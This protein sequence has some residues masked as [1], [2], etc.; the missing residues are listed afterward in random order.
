MNGYELQFYIVVIGVGL[1]LFLSL[2]REILM[3]RAQQT[4]DEKDYTSSKNYEDLGEKID[5]LCLKME[6]FKS[7]MRNSDDELLM[8]LFRCLNE[9]HEEQ[10]AFHSDLKILKSRIEELNSEIRRLQR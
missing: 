7:T 8:S 10:Q 4:F 5:T 3:G 2:L 9:W 6:Y 1:V